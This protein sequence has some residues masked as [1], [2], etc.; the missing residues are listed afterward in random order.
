MLMSNYYSQANIRAPADFS[1]S[2]YTAPDSIRIEIAPNMVS[3]PPVA[4]S[5]F[6]LASPLYS[7]IEETS[8][9]TPASSTNRSNINKGSDTKLAIEGLAGR[10]PPEVQSY[11]SENG[12]GFN[13]S[14]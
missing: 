8:A 14:L 5:V 9:N 11:K 7:R 1:Q 3:P 13:D 10:K 6:H 12:G 2:L 4:S